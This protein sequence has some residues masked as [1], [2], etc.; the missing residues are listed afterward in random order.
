VPSGSFVGIAATVAI[1]QTFPAEA[2]SDCH[3]NLP[4]VF[5]NATMNGSFGVAV[6]V[7]SRQY[8]VSREIYLFCFAAFPGKK[9]PSI[10][11]GN[12]PWGSKDAASARREMRIHL[13]PEGNHWPAK[14]YQPKD[15]KTYAIIFKVTAGSGKTAIRSSIF[16]ILCKSEAFPNVKAIPSMLARRQ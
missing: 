11:S 1:G 3:R 2:K 9:Q 10:V 7:L 16:K 12:A 6:P 8:Y 13:V 5:E 14:A 4:D 15:N